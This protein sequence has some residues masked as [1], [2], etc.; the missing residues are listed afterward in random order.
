MHAYLHSTLAPP[1]MA[2]RAR[3]PRTP[4][5]IRTMRGYPISGSA[6]GDIPPPPSFDI[7]AL[8]GDAKGHRASGDIGTPCK[9]NYIPHTLG[10]NPVMPDSYNVTEPPVISL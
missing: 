10:V 5:Y 3:T 4:Y 7:L 9:I 2:T 1:Y 6:Y 8:T